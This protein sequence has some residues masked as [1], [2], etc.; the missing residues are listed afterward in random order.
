MAKDIEIY[1]YDHE[2]TTKVWRDLHAIYPDV[3]A[4]CQT[5]SET[6]DQFKACMTWMRKRFNN[7]AASYYYKDISKQKIPPV[8]VSFRDT[9]LPIP[10][11]PLV[12]S[13]HQKFENVINKCK[14]D[15]PLPGEN[16]ENR[17][18]RAKFVAA[19][20][21]EYIKARKERA[22]CMLNGIEESAR[23]A[24]V[25]LF[26]ATKAPSKEYEMPTKKKARPGKVEGILAREAERTGWTIGDRIKWDCKDYA[27][28]MNAIEPKLDKYDYYKM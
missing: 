26:A 20:R 17:E 7:R 16:I 19:H 11:D 9:H 13:L 5:W 22:T 12:N 6:K 23:G 1:D 2:L 8:Q 25:G 27:D 14:T 10:P 28:D 4:L 18:E 15:Y 3:K 21:A 24:I